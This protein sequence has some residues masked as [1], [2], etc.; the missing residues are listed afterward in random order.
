MTQTPTPGNPGGTPATPATQPA[1]TTE[2]DTTPTATA[3]SSA[4]GASTPI[5]PSTGTGRE[6]GGSPA[7]SRDALL[8]GLALIAG[9]AATAVATRRRKR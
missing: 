6:G 5:A 9:G 1:L 7:A 2:F 3:T 4:A 8:I